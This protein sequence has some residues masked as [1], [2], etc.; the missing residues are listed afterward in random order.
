MESYS[1]RKERRTVKNLPVPFCFLPTPR[2]LKLSIFFFDKSG[3]DVN[4]LIFLLI[5]LLNSDYQFIIDGY[6]LIF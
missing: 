4:S 2:R 1:D 5:R 3:D 6:Q